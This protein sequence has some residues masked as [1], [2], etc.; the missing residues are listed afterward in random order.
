MTGYR[1]TDTVHSRVL[2]CLPNESHYT[3]PALQVLR[4]GTCRLQTPLLEVPAMSRFVANLCRHNSNLQATIN[5]HCINNTLKNIRNAGLQLRTPIRPDC[6][7][8]R[9]QTTGQTRF[10]MIKTT[11]NILSP[12]APLLCRS[13]RIRLLEMNQRLNRC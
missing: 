2:Y 11:R 8:D 3:V 10:P 7:S 1:V 13:L 12:A 5:F 6:V 4:A 9:R